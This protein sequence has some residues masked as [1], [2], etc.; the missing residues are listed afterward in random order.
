[1]GLLV[2]PIGARNM[3]TR[4][5]MHVEDGYLATIE[6]FKDSTLISGDK[7]GDFI[8]LAIFPEEFVFIGYL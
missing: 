3:R 2:T 4:I 6:R 7:P 5:Y 8:R 1:M